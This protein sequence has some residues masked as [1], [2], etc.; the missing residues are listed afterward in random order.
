MKHVW[1]LKKNVV[2]CQRCGCMM[3]VN[4]QNIEDLIRGVTNIM[5]VEAEY[6]HQFLDNCDEEI[7]HQIIDS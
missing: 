5:Q 6:G 2:F 3:I 1:E 4:Q 7:V